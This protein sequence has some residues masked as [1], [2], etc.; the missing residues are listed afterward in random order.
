MYLSLYVKLEK[1]YILSN[2]LNY[3]TTNRQLDKN[4]PENGEFNS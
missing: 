3:L 4:I 1:N 2:S